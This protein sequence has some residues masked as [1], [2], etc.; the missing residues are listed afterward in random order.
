[1]IVVGSTNPVKVEAVRELRDRWPELAGEIVPV[2]TRTSVPDQPMSLEQTVRG[3]RERAEAAFRPYTPAAVLGVGIESGITRIPGPNGMA[4]YD[5]CVAAVADKSG[6]WIGLSG[7]WEVPYKVVQLLVKGRNLT[8]AFVQ[9]GYS[10][11]GKLGEAEGAIG[12]L[13][14]HRVTRKDYTKQTVEMALISR[15]GRRG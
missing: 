11:N 7:M 15:R 12:V 10:T 3:A 6:M 14:E 4:W 1:M 2:A 9:A 5:V 13:S 8:E